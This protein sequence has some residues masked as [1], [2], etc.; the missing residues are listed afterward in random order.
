MKKL[1]CGLFLVLLAAAIFAGSYI[2]S[3]DSLWTSSD[4]LIA[5]DVARHDSQNVQ[6]I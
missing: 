6:K 5:K 3:Y 4:P 1:I 2:F